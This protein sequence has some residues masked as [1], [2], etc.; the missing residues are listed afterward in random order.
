[1]QAF[2]LEVLT[3]TRADKRASKIQHRIASMAKHE[4]P[5]EKIQ[6]LIWER[7]RSAAIGR[8]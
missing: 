4:V 3:V 6:P 7:A 5:D 1:M 2:F 8:P